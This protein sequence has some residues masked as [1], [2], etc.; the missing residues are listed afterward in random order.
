MKRAVVISCVVVLALSFAASAT[1][2]E[3]YLVVYKKNIPSDVGSQIAG[4]GGVLGGQNP[5]LV[6][7]GFVKLK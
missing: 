1:A 6:I 5:D 3:R 4:A 7:P 2:G